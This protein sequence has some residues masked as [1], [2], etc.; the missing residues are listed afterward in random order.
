MPPTRT[1][2]RKHESGKQTFA[3]LAEVG[4]DLSEPLSSSPNDNPLS[5]K[6]IVVTGSLQQFKRDEIKQLI[7]D[8]GGRAASSVSKKTDY[9]VA[10]DKAGSKLN[11]ARELGVEIL[12]E[13]QFRELIDR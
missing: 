3:E 13:Q 8:L 5:G 2:H 4:V 6:T 12:T 11:K 9:L 10:G 7:D 1:K